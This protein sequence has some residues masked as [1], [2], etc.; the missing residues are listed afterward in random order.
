MRRGLKNYYEILQEEPDATFQE[1]KRSYRTLAVEW[2][3]DRNPGDKSAAERMALINEAYAVLSD[4]KLRAKYDA[5]LKSDH[6]TEAQTYHMGENE[7]VGLWPMFGRDASR[8]RRGKYPSPEEPVKKWSFKKPHSL[9]WICG[10]CF[11]FLKSLSH[12]LSGISL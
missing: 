10:Y 3:P 1:I 6:F 11:P 12:L 2:H 4:E 5:E 9:I 8:M 7:G